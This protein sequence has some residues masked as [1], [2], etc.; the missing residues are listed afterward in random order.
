[1]KGSRSSRMFLAY[2]CG[3]LAS[4]FLALG[5]SAQSLPANLY[6]GMRWRLVGPFRGGRAE[7]VAGVPGE[8]NTYYL[9][10]S[11]AACGKRPRRRNWNPI[12]DKASIS[13]I[14]AI[15]VAPSDHNMIYVGTGEA[16]LRGNITYGDGVYKSIDG[17]QNWTHIGLKDTPPHRRDHRRSGNPNIVFVAALG[18]A[19]GPNE[20][21]GVY[22]TT[23]GG[24]T[25]KKVLVEG[26]KYRRDRCRFRSAQS[27][28]TFCCAL[29]GA[30]AAV[31]F[32]QRRPGQRALP[33]D[34][35][36]RI[37]GSI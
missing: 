2:L 16:A 17:G 20:E 3:I 27:Q 29:P 6:D 30:A 4:L 1:M 35:R 13:S 23:D 11:P 32:L 25:W 24:K 34:R 18:H 37:P 22:R 12:F 36:R 21:R 9:A 19:F 15:A 28:H 7:A 8:P 5:I 10:P 33:F 26:R 31:V 14:G